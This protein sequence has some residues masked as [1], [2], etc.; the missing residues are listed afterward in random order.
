MK[1]TE[2]ILLSVA[3]LGILGAAAYVIYKLTTTKSA[4]QKEAEAREFRK[5]NP[6]KPLSEGQLDNISKSF[7]KSV[8]KRLQDFGKPKPQPT[9]F[10]QSG[11]V[12][13]PSL[14]NTQSSIFQPLNLSN[15]PS[16]TID[17]KPRYLN[18]VGQFGIAGI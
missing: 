6:Y 18:A 5:K 2:K 4:A 10:A 9:P 8:E 16:G 17:F 14:I 11:G 13:S 12:T 3:A 7:S 15:Q 1:T